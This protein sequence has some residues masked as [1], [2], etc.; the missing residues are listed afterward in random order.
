MNWISTWPVKAK[1]LAMVLLPLVALVI[2]MGQMIIRNAGGI[3]DSER[4]QE[5]VSLARLQGVLAHELQK[6]RGMSAG[7]LGSKGS[8]FKTELPNQQQESDRVLGEWKGMLENHDLSGFPK[9][10]EAL[11]TVRGELDKLATTRKSV[12]AQTSATPDVVGFYSGVIDRLLVVAAQATEYSQDGEISRSLQAYYN[13]LQGKERAGIERALLS[14]AFGADAFAAGA[15]SRFI[16]MESEQGAFFQSFQRFADGTTAAAYADFLNSSEQKEVLRM[17]QIAHEK[18]AT[19]GF[20]ISAESWFKAA[21]VRIDRL[22]KIED[23]QEQALLAKTADGLH[24]SE[25]MFWLSLAA[26][27]MILALT[28][29]I[30]LVVSRLLYKQIR[31]LHTSIARISENLDLTVRVPVVVEDELGDASRAFNRLLQRLEETV[32]SITDCATEL[33]LIAIQN[34]MTISLSTRSMQ[35]QQDETSSAAT[36]VNELE[37]ATQEIAT[38]ILHV[39]DKA[40]QANQTV[41]V[42]GAAVDKSLEFIGSLNSQ[43]DQ[44]AAVIQDLNRSSGAISGVLEVIRNIAEQTNL[45]ALNAAIE[46]ARAGEQGRGFAVVADEVRSLA[47]KTQESTAEISRIVGQFQQDSQRAFGSV[48]QSQSVAQQTVELSATVS[49]ELNTIRDVIRSIRDMTDQVASAAEEQVATNKELTRNM[50]SIHR[51]SE[52]TSATGGFMRK[53]GVQQRELAGKLMEMANLFKLSE[54]GTRELR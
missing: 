47:S 31:A 51:L 20:G 45:L 17:R 39:A 26:G 41:E 53:T 2:V 10:K 22:K 40:D 46:A 37:Q 25:Q 11:G 3:Q 33:H 14:A 38:S 36:A 35:A 4:L 48:Q 15:Y 9:L 52:S 54:R 23:V 16:R 13:L 42:S 29:V 49:H 19:G 18:S 12:L 30:T 28:T 7:Y 43:M 32:I 8:S 50:V 21:T 34:H 27:L 6:E 44:A 1:L 24:A 5:L